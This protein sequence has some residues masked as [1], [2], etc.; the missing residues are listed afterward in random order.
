MFVE[1]SRPH[2]VISMGDKSPKAKD[3]SK[4]QDA[5]EKDQKKAAAYA[6]ANS[7]AA[8]KKSK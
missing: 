3:R 6:K 1:H 4:K 5:A 7:A 8:A 2:A